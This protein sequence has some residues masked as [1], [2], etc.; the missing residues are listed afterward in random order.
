MLLGRIIEL[1]VRYRLPSAVF[2]KVAPLIEREL[3]FSSS[4]C[5]VGPDCRVAIRSSSAVVDVAGILGVQEFGASVV[6][7]IIHAGDDDDVVVAVGHGE[8]AHAGGG[9]REH[10]VRGAA[11]GEGRDEAEECGAHLDGVGRRAGGRRRR[12]WD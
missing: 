1:T 2:R 6:G 12:L 10:E 8:G 5:I 11:G 4:A 9:V 3:Q 7:Y